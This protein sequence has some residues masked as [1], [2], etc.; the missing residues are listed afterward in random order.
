MCKNNLINKSRLNCDFQSEEIYMKVWTLLTEILAGLSLSVLLLL[1]CRRSV[2]TFLSPV[3][4][5]GVLTTAG[6]LR[7]C[8]GFAW[9]WWW[10]WGGWCDVMRPNKLAFCVGV[11]LR[12]C[13]ALDGGGWASFSSGSS[14]KFTRILWHIIQ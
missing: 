4:I 9:W 2:S 13:E 3:V 10:W 12:N 1:R 14:C 6:D 8:T 5:T 11:K 7:I